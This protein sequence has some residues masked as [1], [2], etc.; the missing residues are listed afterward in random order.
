MKLGEISL[1]NKCFYLIHIGHNHFHPFIELFFSQF[2]KITA[3]SVSYNAWRVWRSPDKIRDHFSPE[4]S[5]VGYNLQNMLHLGTKFTF[6]GSLNECF[7]C[8]SDRP[9]SLVLSVYTN[10]E[11]RLK[12]YIMF[13]LYSDCKKNAILLVQ[14]VPLCPYGP[15]Y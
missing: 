5:I 15:P 6:G 14:L 2:A 1:W 7:T 10:S 3:L 8:I 4:C 13:S 12:H 9:V 11:A